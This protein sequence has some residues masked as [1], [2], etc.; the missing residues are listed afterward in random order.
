MKKYSKVLSQLRLENIL[1][2]KMT[3][4]ASQENVVF[5][6]QNMKK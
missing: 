2:V 4:E 3:S 6:L 1:K 5:E